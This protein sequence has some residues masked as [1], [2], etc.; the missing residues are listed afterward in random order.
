[1]IEELKQC[2]FNTERCGNL[3]F[4][5]LPISGKYFVSCDCGASGPYEISKKD[6][7]AAW[8]TRKK[9]ND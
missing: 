7:A 4:L 3:Q 6:A 5:Q 2:P 1:M 8:N 9:E